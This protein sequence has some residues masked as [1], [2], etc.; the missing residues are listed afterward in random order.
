VS[1]AVQAPLSPSP[2]PGATDLDEFVR[3]FVASDNYDEPSVELSFCGD[4]VEYFGDDSVGKLFIADDI[5]KYSARWPKR[6]Y[7][8]DGYPTVRVDRKHDTAKVAMTIRF[9][10]QNVQK[11][12]HRAVPKHDS[13][14][15][16]KHKCKSYFRCIKDLES[17]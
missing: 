3:R 17:K 4:S 11:T 2:S 15:R 6:N 14:S 1:C 13:H 5:K 12:D 16:R 8:L 10:V 7:S 9:L